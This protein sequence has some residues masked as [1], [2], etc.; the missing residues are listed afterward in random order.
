MKR[1]PLIS[2][3]LLIP[4]L[5]VAAVHSAASPDEKTSAADRAREDFE[6]MKLFAEAY[7]QID[8]R[9]V[10][11]VDRRQLV[12]AAVRGMTS[13][14]DPYSSYIPPG[15]LSKFEQYLEQ[16]FV[17]VGIHVR[18]QNG[19]AE[20]V[21]LLPGSPAERVGLKPG[22]VLLEVDG[23]SIVGLSPQETGKLLAGPTGRPVALLV[24]RAT[25]GEPETLNLTRETIQLPTVLGVRRQPD[26]TFDFRHAADSTIARLRITHF[27]TN[28]ADEMRSA[29]QAISTADFR[30]LI[31][32]VRSNPGG[33]MD[34]AIS[35]ADMFLDSGTIVSIR[36][37]DEKEKKKWSAR[38]S[39]TLCRLPMVILA[40][41]SSAS[42]SEVLAGC[43]QDNGRAVVVGERTFGKG[44]VQ[45]V[46]QLESGRSALKLTTASYHRPSG[47]NIQRFPDSKPDD[48]W[49]VKPSDGHMVDLSKEQWAEWSRVWQSPD[50]IH[51]GSN[52]T[53]KST[54]PDLQLDHA[55]AFLN[56]QLAEQPDDATT[57]AQ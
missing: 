23:Q 2:A 55:I 50:L 35:I 4:I 3:C 19:N 10:R 51:G 40:N 39:E 26:G 30:G 18:A 1:M 16:E 24:R 14:L 53:E 15:E 45:S 20:I 38:K 17:G 37:R 8:L 13:H 48:D 41:R 47:V 22:D 42:A 28:T 43:L 5:A 56:E 46:V 33:R 9:Y 52:S 21:N 7:E 27:S 29:L 6:L 54:T 32:D 11:D 44:S 34:V 57:V 12:E 36:G 31:L 25:G 49:G